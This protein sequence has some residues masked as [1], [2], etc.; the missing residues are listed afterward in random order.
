MSTTGRPP[1]RLAVT[2]LAALLAGGCESSPPS[3]DAPP[4]SKEKE[5]EAKKVLVAP[6]VFLEVQGQQ[7]RVLVSASVCLREGQLEL[8]MCRKNTKE[9]E[10]ILTADVDAREVHKA[11]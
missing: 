7:R 3:E 9:H 5:A 11:L 10:A 1:H 4:R 8:L 2:I 6:N